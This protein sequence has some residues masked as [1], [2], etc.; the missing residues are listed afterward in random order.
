V[1]RRTGTNRKLFKRTARGFYILNPAMRV[2][3]AGAAGEAE[4]WVPIY[5][6]L[7]THALFLTYDWIDQHSSD[8]RSGDARAPGLSPGLYRDAL[9]GVQSEFRAWSLAVLAGEDPPPIA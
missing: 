7:E 5:D 2:Q 9:K 8:G 4:T 3:L 6:L 1:N